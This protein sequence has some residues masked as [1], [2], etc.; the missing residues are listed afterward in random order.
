MTR[1]GLKHG[2]NHKWKEQDLRQTLRK[3][4]NTLFNMSEYFGALSSNCRHR[5]GRNRSEPVETQVKCRAF[6]SHQ[7]PPFSQVQLMAIQ[8]RG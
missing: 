6:L 8:Q 1:A 7:T 3:R 4:R 5:K 2:Y